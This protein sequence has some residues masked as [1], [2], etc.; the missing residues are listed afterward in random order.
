[1]GLGEYEKARQ[2]LETFLRQEPDHYSVHLMLGSV[3]LDW[4]RLEDA[5]R[6]LEIADS[7][8][9][10]DFRI[11][12]ALS[13]LAMLRDEWDEAESIAASLLES[14]SPVSQRVGRYVRATVLGF[15]GHFTEA[16]RLI[17]Q[18][19]ASNPD[20][21][22]RSDDH[23]ELASL[24]LEFDRP[25]LALDHAERSF[26]KAA[27]ASFNRALRIAALALMRLGD[28]AGAFEKAEMLKERA[29]QLPSDREMRRWHQLRGELALE[30]GDVDR[31]VSALEEARSLL[32]L[33]SM[34][35][36]SGSRV[37]ILRALAAADLAA[38]E[39]AKAEG[40]L[41]EILN[42]GSERIMLP[43][44]WVRSHYLLAQIHERRGDI[45]GAR[46]LYCR[47]YELWRDGDID[48]ER[49]EEAQRKCGN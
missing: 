6:A 3:F 8:R 10:G 36:L 15:R 39:D 12:W 37:S 41:D 33:G 34:G 35:A 18:N 43:E 2:T 47:F 25:E 44:A 30:G 4:G 1:V 11:L 24:Y 45:D 42:A 14:A 27:N 32:P 49:V 23:I 26:E 5:Q 29:E 31:A 48:R 28:T 40:L 17:E 38:G 19:I 9:P 7:I 21:R 16:A 13:I 46:E 20:P 22:T